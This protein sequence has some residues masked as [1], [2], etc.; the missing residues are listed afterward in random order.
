[1]AP[2][3]RAGRRKWKV[4]KVESNKSKQVT[5]ELVYHEY[6]ITA[7]ISKQIVG[8]D[9]TWLSS[10]SS[11]RPRS[12]QPGS[13]SNPNCRPS[14]HL[15]GQPPP[16]LSQIKGAEPPQWLAISRKLLRSL[17]GAIKPYNSG[18][19]D[20]PTPDLQGILQL[21]ENGSPTS[22]PKALQLSDQKITFLRSKQDLTLEQICSCHSD[23]KDPI[24]W[25]AAVRNRPRIVALCG[26]SFG[27][28]GSAKSS[29]LVE[30][31]GTGSKP[32][33]RFRGGL[34]GL[35]SGIAPALQRYA[36][37]KIPFSTR[38]SVTFEGFVGKGAL[39][40]HP[41]PTPHHIRL[42]STCHFSSHTSISHLL[43]L[44]A[45]AGFFSVPAHFHFAIFFNKRNGAI[46]SVLDSHFHGPFFPQLQW[47]A[48]LWS[49]FHFMVSSHC[50]NSSSPLFRDF[51]TAVENPFLCVHLRRIR[52]VRR[53]E[54][55]NSTPHPNHIRLSSTRHF[56]SRTSGSHLLVLSVDAVNGK[57][58]ESIIPSFKMM[59]QF[60]QEWNIGKD[61]QR[62][63]F[64]TI[65]NILRDNKSTSREFTFLSKFLTTFSLEKDLTTNE[66]KE[67]V[68][69]AIM[70][71][72]KSPNMFHC[73]LPDM[74]VI[75]QLENDEKYALAY[76]LLEIFLTR[77]LDSYI[78]F[79]TA[80]SNFLKSHGMISFLLFS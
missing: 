5:A 67:K 75:A 78:D 26:R 30:M 12:T 50:P 6:K 8:S 14:G 2:R 76:Q 56:S 58:T 48:E 24:R 52:R 45:D 68:V 10:S 63:L 36:L 9:G 17:R 77:R 29:Q 79:N 34:L 28:V 59:D 23:L 66:E 16:P 39:I 80:N 4:F 40:P 41:T 15:P 7:S 49:W 33:G 1:M 20:S 72:V 46:D 64:L 47:I 43:A 60:L 27:A 74:P 37:Q 25:K 61:E 38:I 55:A 11:Q 51:F 18:W 70:E 42:S 32:R 69:H 53:Q 22:G 19:E 3:H 62:D 54:C 65:S 35:R 21:R 44:S 57:V 73:D 13:N 71:C 31:R